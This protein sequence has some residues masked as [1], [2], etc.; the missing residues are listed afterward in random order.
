[1]AS[2]A[3]LSVYQYVYEI[4]NPETISRLMVNRKQKQDYDDLFDNTNFKSFTIEFTEESFQDL[5]SSMQ[6][7]FETYGTYQDNTMHKVNVIYNDGLGNSFTI[8]EVGFRTK[9][10]TSRNLPL[11]FD[12]MNRATYHQTSFQI[13]FDA[14]F[15]YIDTS[16]EYTVLN[17]REAFNLDQLNFEYCKSFDA[18]YDEA[19]ISEAYAYQ[20]YADADVIASKATYG[21]VYLKIDEMLINYGF[22]TIIEPIDQEFLKKNFDSDLLGDFSDLYKATDTAGPA[23]LSLNYDGLIGI[24]EN[25][26]N[27]RF[28]YALKNNSIDGLRTQHTILIDFIQDINT[29]DIFLANAEKLIDT[30]LFARALAIGF[31]IGNTDDYRYNYNNYYLYFD[32]Y[33]N[34]ATFIPFDL[35]NALGFGKHQDITYQFGLNYPLFSSS[36]DPAI[37]VSQFLEVPEYRN[38][39]LHYLEEFAT[40]LFKYDDFLV[41]YTSARNLYQDILV[42]ENHLGN[43]VFGLRNVAYYM[44]NKTNNV[45]TYLENE[46]Y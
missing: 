15:D 29:L 28:S 42:N 43:Q 17:S 20:L 31:L 39:Y 7:Y 6:T 19:M 38:L 1:M 18:D 33:T 9:S 45:L 37:L 5:L 11:T 4:N 27:E 10:N 24:N 21:I 3:I 40:N 2:I 46:T 41:E 44:V 35:D 25:E 13:Q 30:D 22:Y 23:D 8:E 12:W 36:D 16:N 14:T 26:I 32:V 34:Q